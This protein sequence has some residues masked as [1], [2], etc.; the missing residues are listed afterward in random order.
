MT[1]TFMHGFLKLRDDA[2]LA[3]RN[4]FLRQL[5]NLCATDSRRDD[6]DFH[7]W[8]SEAP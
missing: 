2:G 4:L 5:F 8:L 6:G 3:L 7:A 1:K